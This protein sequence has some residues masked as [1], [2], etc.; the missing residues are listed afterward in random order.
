MTTDLLDAQRIIVPP[1]G[2]I[3]LGGQNVVL[4]NDARLSNS[5]APT[6]NAG[7][8]LTGTYPNPTLAAS[9]VTSGTYR[10][11]TVDTKGRVT[12]GTNPTTLSGYG[13]TDAQP[14]DTELTA[15]AGLASQAD[16][17]PYFNGANSAALAV[18][19]QIGRN[20][21]AAADQPAAR[22]ALGLGTIATQS[23][24]NVTITGGTIDNVVLDGGT[25]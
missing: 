19:T 22:T 24:S 16:R 20:V 10:S 23:A 6:G 11:V 17:L 13:I 4:T 5:R 25:F 3:T 12:A 1:S 9:G 21:V 18:F 7:G 14:L 15:I 8:D 2:A